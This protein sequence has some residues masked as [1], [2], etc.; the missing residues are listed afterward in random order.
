MI[1]LHRLEGFYWVCQC[2]GYAAAAR[3]VP[4]PITQPALHQQVRKLEKEL[5]ITLLERVGKS[6]M[7]PTPAGTLLFDFVAPFFRNLGGIVEQ[8]RKG[9]YGGTLRLAAE[10]MPIRELL[11]PWLTRLRRQ[12]PDVH[13]DLAEVPQVD[14]ER[15][16]SG[17]VDA[18][19]AYLPDVPDDIAAIDVATLHPFLV[20]PRRAARSKGIKAREL[21]DRFVSYRPG[22]VAHDL[23]WRALAAQQA[24]P[25]HVI[26]VDSTETILGFV[27]SGLGFSLVPSLDPAGPKGRTLQSLPIKVPGVSLS[28][29]LAWRKD[30]AENPL[31]DALI[32]N[33]PKPSA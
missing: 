15:V 18:M 6:T 19:I 29:S 7:Q 28:V 5:G 23:Q 13:I 12:S 11:P 2:R 20:V 14:L 32:E 10:P 33:A 21:R 31:L 9:D 3:T 27:A 4:F 30:A 22:T 26:A 8:V 17:S 16:R 1:S 25:S 24:N